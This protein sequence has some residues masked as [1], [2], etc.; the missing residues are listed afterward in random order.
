METAD[1]IRL[2]SKLYYYAA[3]VTD[4]YD[5]DTIT[6]DIDLGLGIWRKEQ[7]IRF[8]KVN[9]PEVRGAE[10]EE[11]LKVRD[12]VRELL[13]GKDILLRT[14]LDKRGQDRTGKFGRL[15][16]EILIEDEQGQI[17]NV[18]DLLLEQN[19]G[20]VVTEDGTTVRPPTPANLP[21]PGG[22]RDASEERTAD[23]RMVICI[24]CGSE[25]PVNPS[26]TVVEPCP[27]CLDVAYS[28]T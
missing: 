24:Y 7:T 10:R 12:F 28:L 27:N 18:N 20:L 3:L 19:M 21:I 14:I 26:V 1:D 9:T 6:V 23:T 22:T 15:L 4:V 25:R 17:V 8:W 11:G 2:K 5:G 13:L 16:G